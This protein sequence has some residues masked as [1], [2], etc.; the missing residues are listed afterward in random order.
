MA[1]GH[2]HCMQDSE[3]QWLNSICGGDI[4]R[5]TGHI[6]RHDDIRWSDSVEHSFGQRGKHRGGECDD[7]RDVSWTADVI[8]SSWSDRRQCWQ[9]EHVVIGHDGDDQ[10]ESWS[11]IHVG[12]ISD[13]DGVSRH[14]SRA[15]DMGCCDAELSAEKQRRVNRVDECDRG[16]RDDRQDGIDDRDGPYRRH[17]GNVDSVDLIIID[18][19]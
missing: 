7:G 16:G 8:E 4:R 3:W 19:G 1:I 11:I 6:G 12:G 5:A 14:A 13:S 15:D 18:C 10:G 2:E 17:D 9:C